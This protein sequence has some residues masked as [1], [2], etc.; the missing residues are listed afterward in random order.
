VTFPT[1]DGLLPGR[2]ARRGTAS[3]WIGFAAVVGVATADELYALLVVVGGAAL[4]GLIRAVAQPLWG[5]AAVV[6]PALALQTGVSGVRSARRAPTA[7]GR[8]AQLGSSRALALLLAV[9]L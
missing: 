7:V 5:T 6:L 1:G 4:T 3:W 8:P 2:T 9:T